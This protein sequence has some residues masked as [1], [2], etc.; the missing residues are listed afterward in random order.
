MKKEI[1]TMCS[2][3]KVLSLR[4]NMNKKYTSKQI[5]DFI[6]QKKEPF[7]LKE[8]EG[9]ALA[10]FHRAAEGVPAYKDFLAKNRI[11]HEKVT[12]W[13]DFQLVPPVSKKNY[14]QQYPLE[15]LCWG[16]TLE[17][18]ITFSATSGSTGEPF[19]F[20]RNEKLE[21][22]NSILSE[23]FLKNVDSGLGGGG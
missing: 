19:Y 8:R 22:E 23:L 9:R 16:G 6:R 2:T 4:R 14:L 13:Q 15:M 1:Q 3:R 17:R 20:P 11:Q 7:W 21:F 12:T 5:I 18:Q 10:L